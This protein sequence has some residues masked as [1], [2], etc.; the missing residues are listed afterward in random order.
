M[1][2]DPNLFM[3][4]APKSGTTAFASYL[5]EHPDVFVAGKEL[6]YFSFDL[7]FSTMKG[8]KWRITR[9]AYLAW[10]SDNADKRYR[11]DHSVFYLYSQRAAR[12]IRDFAPESR[13][14]IMLRNPV[15]Q[16][17]SQHSEMLFQG[18]E[19]LR[20]FT[21]ALAAEDDRK[22]GTRIPPR[23]RKPFG[24]FYRDL[25][26]YA[27]QVERYFSVFGRDRVCVILYDDMVAETARTYRDTLQFL[28]IDPDFT[29]D[30]DV[31]NANKVVRST[32]TREF[33]RRTPTPARRLGRLL[34]RDE[35]RRAGMRRR[36][37]ALNTQ[38]RTRPALGS[39]LRRQ[40]EAE[41]AP[42]VRRLEELLGRDL[43]RWRSAPPGIGA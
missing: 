41:F 4:G 21:E 9:E 30:F 7:D 40:L 5:N 1:P 39:G 26:R 29:P 13:I 25:A 22:H 12:E 24:L 6:N 10:F 23:C 34:V 32:L 14:I 31:V 35:H 20:D 42:E 8:E 17:Y 36:L 2:A 27:E 15:D 37:H 16:M 11:G 28:G 33:L 3:V 38:Q 18:D 19:N 43:G